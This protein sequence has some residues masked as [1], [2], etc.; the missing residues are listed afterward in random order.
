M[1]M[2]DARQIVCIQCPQGCTL[3]AEKL[4]TVP[5]YEITGNK[6]PRGRAYAIKE[7]T[8]PSR[9]LTT[10]VATIFSDCPLVSVRTDGDIPLRDVFRAM[11]ELNSY[12]AKKRLHPGE[13][14]IADLAG[15][16]VALL[17]TSDMIT[18]DTTN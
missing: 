18:P 1:T 6:C 2:A 7:L 8:N 9:T 11:Q 12:R 5:S 16:G 15:T 17:A 13:V 4:G 3:R 10:T 14:M